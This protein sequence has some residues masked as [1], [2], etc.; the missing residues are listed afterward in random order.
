MHL[1]SFYLYLIRAK[2]FINRC[3]KENRKIWM[4]RHVDKHKNNQG[5]QF[6]QNDVY[7]ES[8]NGGGVEMIWS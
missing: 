2:G 8:L 6:P 4:G 7:N 1:P 5:C 3:C